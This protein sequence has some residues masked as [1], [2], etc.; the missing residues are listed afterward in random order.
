MFNF[1]IMLDFDVMFDFNE[2]FNFDKM[3]E[4]LNLKKINVLPSKIVKNCQFSKNFKVKF[5]FK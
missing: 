5:H 2:M 4:C 1:D 3:S